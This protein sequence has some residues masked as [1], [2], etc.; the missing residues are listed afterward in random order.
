[1]KRKSSAF[2]VLYRWRYKWGAASLSAWLFVTSGLW[3]LTQPKALSAEENLQTFERQKELRSSTHTA[4]L[5][6]RIQTQQLRNPY[7]YA[8]HG[9][10]W[11]AENFWNQSYWEKQLQQLVQDGYNAVLYMTE[12]WQEHQWQTF[13]I[14]HKAFPEAQE[15]TA[16][17]SNRII[18][19]VNWI[20]QRGHELGLKNFLWSYF[21]V[22]TR[23]FA[24]AHDMDKEMPVSDTVDYRHNLKEMGPHFGVRNELTRAFTEAAIAELFQT[25]DHLDGLCGGMGEA[26][27]GKRSTWYK[28][29]IV[30]GLMRSGRNPIFI[31]D[32]WML[33]FEDFLADIAPMEVYQKTW[34]SIKTNGE[35][36]TDK[37]PYPT[38]VLWAEKAQVPTL[39]QIMS[40]NIEANFPF[41]SPKLA[42]EIIEEFQ[43]VQNC[44]GFVSWF[45]PSNPND[46]FRKA[47]GYYGS[48]SEP[49]SDEPWIDLL[50]ERF[51]DRRAA[52]HLLKALD[53]SA[54]IAMEVAAIA[55]SPQ[56]I[57]HSHQLI[58]PYWHWTD[59]NPRW[60]YFPSPARGT[61]LLPLRYY[62]RVVAKF[63]DM[64]LDNN[65]ANYTKN[66]DHPG[67]QELIWGLTRYPT[68]PSAHMRNIRQLGE[69]CL[70]SAEKAMKTVKTNVDQATTLYNYMKAYKLLTDYY[71]RK[72]SV[73]IAAL[74][75]SFGGD[76]KYKTLAKTKADEAVSLYETA[77]EFIWE[78]IDKKN[79]D[80]KG[81]WG[82]RQLTL[83][84]LIELERDERSRLATLFKWPSE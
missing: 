39:C 3:G 56:D 22:T 4:V 31:V 80:I 12:P 14:A 67:A 61:S 36:I 72:V 58:L 48:V 57:G 42:Y 76:I 16:E 75:Y 19:H 50:T 51:G 54:R 29:A 55:W 17:Q 82:G 40:L 45:L 38:S 26:L 10:L 8:E 1:M 65:G 15:L 53:A 43:K 28:E 27:P 20:F 6:W 2:C 25:Y 24:K 63:G 81:K 44:T 77:I 52:A 11:E 30:P 59:E 74:I 32:D 5:E 13:L 71:E 23:S 84:E 73:A 66:T 41:N 35:M 83:P 18:E 9:E 46:L 34:L 47:L 21:V 79:G 33:P 69:E 78:H 49:Y 68:T 7:W 62:A 37:K 64:F 60:N 70:A